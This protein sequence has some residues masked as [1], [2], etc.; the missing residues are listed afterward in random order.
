VSE[1]RIRLLEAY[2]DGEL[3]W[4]DRWRARRLLSRD[5]DA[6]AILA[7]LETVGGLL[8]EIEA[9]ASAP[10]LWEAVR[11]RL[12]A[13]D[14][15]R[16]GAAAAEASSLPR[17][18]G[19]GRAVIGLQLVPPSGSGAV[20]WLDSRGSPVVVLQDDRDAT[21]IW[22][23]EAPAEVSGRRGRAVS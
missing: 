22:L 19:A 12:P 18:I 7:S 14:A 16:S 9:E 1:R 13:L 4:L 8:R 5:A 21:I 23:L 20:R 17:W 11:L 15:R 6:R 2:H 10:D 3:G